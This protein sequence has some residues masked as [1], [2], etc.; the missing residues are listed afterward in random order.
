[1]RL[2][3]MIIVPLIL[4]SITSG[5][6]GLGD[7]KTLGRVGIKTFGYYLLSSM[8]AILIG[9]VLTNIIKPGVGAKVPDTVEEFDPSQLQQ[10]DALGG[11]FIRMIP[12]N[13]VKA[14]AEGD[15]LGVIF[16]SIILG[17]AITQLKGKPHKFLVN[18]FDNSFQA[19]MKL[20]QAIIKLAP[21]GVFGLI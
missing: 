15:I 10:P 1:M 17:F 11:I 7:P 16:F 4:T 8:L 9:L 3:K 21:I 14:A 6:A 5:V 2:L 19:M 12:T 20:T 13:P 18:L